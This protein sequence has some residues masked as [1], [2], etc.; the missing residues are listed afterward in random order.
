MRVVRGMI[1]EAKKVEKG[2]KKVVWVVR[3]EMEVKKVVWVVMEV[4]KVEMGVE[5][6]EMGVKKVEMGVERVEMGVEMVMGL[7]MAKEWELA[8]ADFYIPQ[9]PMDDNPLIRIQIVFVEHQNS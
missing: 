1:E 5:R 9:Y 7:E 3:V 2:T 8:E 6:V 4:K